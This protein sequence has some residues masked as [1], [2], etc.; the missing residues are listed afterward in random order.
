M[1]RKEFLKASAIA[2][3]GLFFRLPVYNIAPPLSN[4]IS[5]PIFITLEDELFYLSF[6]RNFAYTIGTSVIS[7]LVT[8]YVKT[9][10]YGNEDA[11]DLKK[12]IEATNKT[13]RSQGF[14]DLSKAK[15]YKP[16]SYR[17]SVIMYQ[18]TNPNN[19]NACAPIFNLNKSV[20]EPV[21]ML[22]APALVGLAAVGKRFKY[23]SD[24]ADWLLPTQE[25]AQGRGSFEGGYEHPA[26]YVSKKG[27]VKID[28]KKK[29]RKKGIVTVGVTDGDKT[30]ILT[31]TIPINLV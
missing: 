6:L 13:M 2:S 30:E 7:N 12:S 8:D 3:M 11:K 21:A 24:A 15:V 17:D 23:K 14:S 20:D 4:P 19:A 28:Y 18:A 10:W 16:K 25:R 26:I 5:T 9:L 29:S 1:N 31:D 22:E 27:I